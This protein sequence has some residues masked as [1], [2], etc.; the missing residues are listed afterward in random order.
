[1][2]KY[3]LMQAMRNREDCQAA[4]GIVEIDDAD[5]GGYASGMRRR[6]ADRK[7]PLPAL[8]QVGAD[9][10]TGSQHESANSQILSVAGISGYYPPSSQ[11][12]YRLSREG[13][14]SGTPSARGG[15][16][17]AHTGAPPCSEGV[18]QHL[19]L[20]SPR[21]G[22]LHFAWASQSSACWRADESR[23]RSRLD[24]DRGS[25]GRRGSDGGPRV[26]TSP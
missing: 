10:Q 2:V 18:E 25:A 15:A 21:G 7:T 16:G 17:G 19:L 1:M 20:T 14:R 3:E 23:L 26:S 9:G 22:T 4:A 12:C 24:R 5:L 13:C 8:A 6:A 11:R